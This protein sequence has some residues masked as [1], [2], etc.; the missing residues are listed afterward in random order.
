MSQGISTQQNTYAFPNISFNESVLGPIPFT[1][2][3][4]NTIGVAG[5]FPRGPVG[6]TRI[7]SRQD[8][9]SIFGEDDSKGAIFIRQAMQ[10]G[11]TNFVISR[12]L[13]SAKAGV[14][15][16][17]LSSGTNPLYND[18]TVA[19]TG[20]RTVG[21]R[22]S[23]SYIGSPLLSPGQYIGAPVATNDTGEISIPGFRGAGFF[24]F[25]VAEKIDPSTIV[26]ADF[27]TNNLRVAAEGNIQVLSVSDAASIAVLRANAKP[28]TVIKKAAADASAAAIA[29]SGLKVLSYAYQSSTEVWSVLVQG[30]VTAGTTNTPTV[31]SIQS[32]SGGKYFVVAYNYRGEESSTL[33]DAT[34]PTQNYER[35]GG[36][37]LGFVTVSVTNKSLQELALITRTA[38]DANLYSLVNTGIKV[39]I[40]NPATS[41]ETEMLLGSTFTVGFAAQSVTI[42]ETDTTAV[43]FPN[44]DR[45]FTPGTS[46]LAILEQLRSAVLRNQTFSRFIN[47]VSINDA[48][49]PFS[50]TLVTG[51]EGEEANRVHYRLTRT[52]SAGNPQDILYGES[53]QLY[54][55]VLHFLN[56]QDSPRIAERYLYDQGGNPLV[57][58][59]ALSPGS[60]G[61]QIRVTVR[62]LKNGQFRLD[63]YDDASNA[64]NVSIPPESYI[65][66]NYTVSQNSGLY[67]ETVGSRLIR[68]YFLPVALASGAAISQ[69]VYQLTPQRVAPPLASL[70]NSTVVANPLHPSHRGIAYL[71]DLYLADGYESADFELDEPTE[72]DYVEAIQRLESEDCSII[73]AAGIV[74]GDIRYEA[75]VSELLYQAERSTCY[76]GLRTAVVSAPAKLSGNRAASLTA[77][78]S[79]DRLTIV[80]GWSTVSGLSHLGLNSVPPDGIYAGILASI[81]PHVSPAAVYNGR[82]ANGVISCDTLLDPNYL[83]QVTRA[84]VEVLY[85]DSGMQLYKFLNGVTTT[86]VAYNQVISLRR[87]SDQMI[88]DMYRN[89]QWVRSYPNTNSLRSRAATAVDAYLRSLVRE[90]KIYGYR[91][92]ICNESNNTLADIA[93]R[94]LNIRVTYTPNYPADFMRVDMNRDITTEL[95]LASG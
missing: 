63:V 49:R 74:A 44:T 90:E 4:R 35:V 69:A 3:W 82:A 56:G 8:F 83:D 21:M 95:S 57:L 23:L 1:P 52:V 6:P 40:G 84:K 72:Q 2:Q 7:S 45:A 28:G 78:L 62:P 65:L 46:S 79:S 64:Y 5:V 9:A 26:A 32:P 36:V 15:T 27:T 66:N 85:F 68:A 76:N 55:T 93:A 18:A 60:S 34:F 80:G 70:A 87:Q 24:D 42:G 10:Q 41:I 88:M 13:P 29:D 12:V 39:A 58:I 61:N 81:P 33:P 67:S 31:L 17:S 54:N 86:S 22:M 48:L 92:T 71:K 38:E 14:S 75:A 89:L 30:A 77:G 47:D 59:E 25:T 51:F 91:P 37:A 20:D 73:A 53:G 43:G 50:A 19:P 94:R 16:I 11:A